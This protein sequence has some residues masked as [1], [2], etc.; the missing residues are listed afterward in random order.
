MVIKLSVLNTINIKNR[1]QNKVVNIASPKS[2][3][4]R[5]LRAFSIV[6]SCIRKSNKVWWQGLLT[7]HQSGNHPRDRIKHDIT[8][9]QIRTN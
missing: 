6:F 3:S 9:K 2:C 5:H 1:T 7:L 8:E 4:V